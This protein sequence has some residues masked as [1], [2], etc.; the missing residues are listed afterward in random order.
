MSSFKLW[1]MAVR[2]RTLTMGA[3]PV[4]VGCAVARAEGASL[5]WLL[6]LA[7]LLGAILIQAATNLHNDAADGESGAD[8]P[9]R[10]G[11]PRVTAQGLLPAAS[12]RRA[13]WGCFAGASLAGLLM[14]EQGGWPILLLGLFS[15]LAGWSYTG[16]PKPI[17]YTPLGELF[18]LAFFGVGAVEG[19]IWL[20]LHRL[21]WDGLLAGAALG[22]FASAVL[23][24]NNHRDHVQDIRS[25]RR[26]LAILAGQPATSWLYGLFMGLPF[27]LLPAIGAGHAWVALGAVPMAWRLV[28][29]FGKTQGRGFNPILGA[30]AQTQL[31]FGLLLCLGVQL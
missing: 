5:D 8:G 30:T 12:V 7:A 11:P 20:Q 22:L 1:M 15:I 18:V 14:L 6:A 13:A 16:G 2:P 31:L 23:L 24:T 28:G 19:T 17:A 21:S 3:V 25:G 9:D 4:L 29:I 10:L 27:L 26:T